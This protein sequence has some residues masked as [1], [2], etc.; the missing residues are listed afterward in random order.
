MH[1]L[2]RYVAALSALTFATTAHADAD[3]WQSAKTKD[4][5]TAAALTNHPVLP[6]ILL[7]CENPGSMRFWVM[8]AE[9]VGTPAK[10]MPLVLR[11]NSYGSERGP[12]L[13][14]L[15]PTDVAREYITIAD[16]ALLNLLSGKGSK[17]WFDYSLDGGQNF[18]VVKHD[19]SLHG[20]TAAVGAA[21]QACAPAGGT[22]NHDA[23]PTSSLEA[24]VSA[25]VL[26]GY[27][28]YR[29]PFGTAPEN[30][31][32]LRFSDGLSGLID[33]SPDGFLGYDP[34]CMCQDYDEAKF[35]YA[36]DSVQMSGTTRATV[37][38]RVA[39]VGGMKP[40]PIQLNMIM[41]RGSWVVDDVTDSN[42][43]LRK[44]LR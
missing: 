3:R 25:I 28:F 38:L 36:I 18:A 17:M 39:A 43:S 27:A 15:Q 41:E 10:G 30:Y 24:E 8:L 16:D 33:R 1:T 37:K 22:V 44:A 2:Y 11:M 5:G 31:P 6:V 32:T 42:G 14:T 9:N 34:F 35:F 7:T 4:F 20:S 21:R 29:F 26:N 13:V 23:S 19:I 40:E 12:L